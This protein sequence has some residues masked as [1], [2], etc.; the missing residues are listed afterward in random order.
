MIGENLL[1]FNKTQ[2]Y[3][4]WDTETCNLNLVHKENVPWQY[5]W[6]EATLDNVISKGNILIKWPKINISK[7]AA[8]ITGFSQEAVD[9]LGISPEEALRKIDA[10]M[11][12]PQYLLVA[13]NGLNFDVYL[14]NIHRRLLGKET[15]YSYIERSIDTVAL[16]RAIK[17]EV[18]PL[19][20]EDKVLFQYK[21]ANTMRKGIKTSIASLCQEMDIPYDAQ[22]AHNA[23]YDV[24]LLYQIW[25]QLVWKI[26]I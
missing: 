21:F 22:L 5:A 18:Q 3:I 9:T 20:D 17:Y 26:E 25:K 6:I 12:D 1:R 11:Y 23:S 14:H 4:F 8:M 10:F 24:N 19:P 13:H 16:A 7:K 15:D 2:K